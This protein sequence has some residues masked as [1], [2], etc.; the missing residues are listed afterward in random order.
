MEE[1]RDVVGAEGFYIVSSEGRIRSLPRRGC[2][3]QELKVHQR[4]DGYLYVQMS[5]EG[6]MVQSGVHRVVAKAFIPNPDN[7]REVNHIN[8]IK[9][10]NRVENLEWVTPSENAIHATEMGLNDKRIQSQS[11]PILAIDK[12]TGQIVEYPSAREAGRAL[13]LLQ[14][15]ISRKANRTSWWETK[16]D[17]YIFIYAPEKGEDDGKENR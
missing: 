10:D 6:Q 15:T 7:K 9:T 4:R 13:G 2:K 16:A 14:S 17:Q 8:T 3:G 1:W 5:V 11:K 12:A